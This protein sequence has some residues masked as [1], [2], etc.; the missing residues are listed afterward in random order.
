MP[1]PTPAATN[2]APTPAPAADPGANPGAQDNATIRQMREQVDAANKAARDAAAERDALQARIT[3]RER[4]EMAEADRLKAEL[5]DAQGQVAELAPLRDEHGKFVSAFEALYNDELAAAPEE[6]RAALGKLSASGSWPDR[7]EA[8]RTAKGLLPS[9]TPAAA[10][11]MTNP[12]GGAPT[13][14]GLPEPQAFDWK[15]PPPWREVLSQPAAKGTP[16]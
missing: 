6:Q 9:A 14:P 3:E 15:N 11:S 16:V 2:P 1:D 10:G 13:T 7:L 8:L 4:A 12:A 5:A